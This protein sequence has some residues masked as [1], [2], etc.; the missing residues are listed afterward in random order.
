[1]MI[2]FSDMMTLKFD[3]MMLLLGGPRASREEIYIRNMM[4]FQTACKQ[5]EKKV[6]LET[7]CHQVAA[8]RFYANT[9]WTEVRSTVRDALQFFGG[10]S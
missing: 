10:N 5:G 4:F 6:V 8:M 2:G 9:G 3:D 7:S 1:M